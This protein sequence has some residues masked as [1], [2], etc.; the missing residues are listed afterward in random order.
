MG[1]RYQP[2]QGERAV[3]KGP[4]PDGGGRMGVAGRRGRSGLP[5]DHRP[6][7]PQPRVHAGDERLPDRA[8]QAGAGEFGRILRGPDHPGRPAHHD[9]DR[10]GAPGR[11]GGRRTDD[12]LGERVGPGPPARRPVVDR[13]EHGRDP[14]RVRRTRLRAAPAERCD[15]GHRDGGIRVQAL[16]A[17]GERETGRD[18]ERHVLGRLAADLPGPRRAG[19]QRRRLLLRQCDAREGDGL[20]DEHALR[21]PQP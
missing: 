6:R 1:S 15:A 19:D 16:R 10:E 9:D 7:L 14:R 8:H 2:R 13:P 5:R 20:L 18:R 12:E 11:G 17:A 21:G 3:G 4:G